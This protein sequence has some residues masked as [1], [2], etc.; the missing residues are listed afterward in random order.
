MIIL[1]NDIAYYLGILFSK[2]S[3]TVMTA[4][5]C[6]IKTSLNQLAVHT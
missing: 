3:N 5:E 1:Q 6:G 2:D 4:F